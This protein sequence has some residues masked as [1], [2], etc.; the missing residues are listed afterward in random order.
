MATERMV[1][2]ALSQKGAK[3][4]LNTIY[5]ARVKITEEGGDIVQAIIIDLDDQI[6]QP[7]RKKGVKKHG[8]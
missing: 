1:H 7:K 4:L 5:R 6:E 2:L 8:N 3:V